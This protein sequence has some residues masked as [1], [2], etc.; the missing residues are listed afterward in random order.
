[1]KKRPQRKKIEIKPC[2]QCY[3][4][5][6]EHDPELLIEH[7]AKHERAQEVAS[8]NRMWNAAVALRQ[9][10]EPQV[11]VKTK[12][13]KKVSSA[14]KSETKRPK[15]KARKTSTTEKSSKEGPS[16]CP[17]PKVIRASDWRPVSPEEQLAHRQHSVRVVK[18]RS[19]HLQTPLRDLIGEL[20][21]GVW[22]FVGDFRT[23]RLASQARWYVRH[24]V[25]PHVK[26]GQYEMTTFGCWEFWIKYEETDAS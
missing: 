8:M 10:D 16:S 21:P 18:G 20:Q 17:F 5:E 3:K 24:K 4:P 19:A 1:M 14:K 23:R 2:P 9:P 25:L 26:L 15:K 22:T 11:A 7:I 6:N 12:K 13:K